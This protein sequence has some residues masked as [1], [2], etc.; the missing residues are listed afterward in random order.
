M[1]CCALPTHGQRLCWL[2][3]I[4]DLSNAAAENLKNQALDEQSDLR[5]LQPDVSKAVITPPTLFRQIDSLREGEHVAAISSP[6]LLMYRSIP[7]QN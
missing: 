2:R 1:R 5:T 4:S 7:V 3:L 6:L